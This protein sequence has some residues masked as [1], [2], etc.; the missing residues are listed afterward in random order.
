MKEVQSQIRINASPA[1]VWHVLG[2]IT[3]MRHYMLGISQVKLLSDTPNGVGAARHC[4]FEDGIELHERVISWQEGRGYEL[5]TTRFV[6]V[7][8]KENRITFALEAAENGTLVTQTMRYKMKGG[9]LAPLME[10]MAAGTMK[11]AIAN[12]LH[13]LKEYTETQATRLEEDR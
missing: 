7:P 11:K 9:L 8:L 13:G 1:E 5:E 10:R 12:A 2:D 4:T 3:N 6:N